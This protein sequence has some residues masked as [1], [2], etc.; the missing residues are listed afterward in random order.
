MMIWKTTWWSQEKHYGQD[1]GKDIESRNEYPVR[2][3]NVS[4]LLSTDLTEV[5][6]W[7]VS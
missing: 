1:S 4:D 3:L 2:Q 5:Y 7:K 6:C